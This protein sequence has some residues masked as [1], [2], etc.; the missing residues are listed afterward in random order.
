MYLA[1]TRFNNKTL[2]ENEKYIQN[3]NIDGVIY[4]C[5]LKINNKYPLGCFMFVIEMNNDKNEIIG[6]SMIKNS[7]VFNIKNVNNLNIYENQNKNRFIYKGKIKI[8]REFILRKNPQLVS[9]LDNILFKGKGHLKRLDGIAVLK[10]KLLKHKN[11][12]GIDLLEEVKYLFK[13]MFFEN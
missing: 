1:S 8:K 2:E 10:E 9:I 6:I 7:L 13:E 3:N 4:G 12:L 11:C 5:P